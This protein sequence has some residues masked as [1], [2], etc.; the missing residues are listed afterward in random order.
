MRNDI[1]TASLVRFRHD[2]KTRSL[3]QYDYGIKLKFVDV[4]LPPF[5]EVHFSNSPEIGTAKTSI[6]D[7]N[8][9]LIPDEYLR[10]GS[11]VYA[12]LFVHTGNDDGETVYKI[13]IPVRKRPEPSDEQPTPQE[14]SVIEQAI[15][16]LNVAIERTS[17][18]EQNAAESA[19]TASQK[20]SEASAS[21]TASANSASASEQSAQASASSASQSAQSATASANSASQSAQS[22]SASAQSASES[23]TSADRAEQ[24]A[25]QAGYMFFYIDEHGDLIYQ[26]TPNTQVDFYLH[27]GDLYVRASA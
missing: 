1:V 19:E 15:A 11:Y 17:A 6:G 2:E 26:R 3:F 24:A 23:A 14:Q 4:D 18:S 7:E 22:A 27:D 8:G 9:V 16:A 5:Y 20:A 12:W 13:T 25:A 10:T 21:A